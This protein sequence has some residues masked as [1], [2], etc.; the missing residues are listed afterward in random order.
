MQE[1]AYVS[2]HFARMCYEVSLPRIILMSIY[3]SSGPL[4]TRQ[5][6]FFVPNIR[7]ADRYHPVRPI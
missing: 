2:I 4:K 1:K 3:L 6:A 5:F 7:L